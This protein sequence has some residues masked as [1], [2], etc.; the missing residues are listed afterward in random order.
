MPSIPTI[1]A[2]GNVLMSSSAS[3]NEWYLNGVVIFGANSQFYTAISNGF[4]VVMVANVSGCIAQS[5]A[6]NYST[7]GISEVSEQTEIIIYPNPFAYQAVLET[8]HPLK[9]ATI[10]IVNLLGQ[11]V[12]QKNNIDGQKIIIERNN[13]PAGVYFIGITENKK[14][15]VTKKIVV[16]D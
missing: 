8:N 1:T 6:Y 14:L 13:M 11:N 5:A 7:T 3:D 2:S 4:Y 16:A 9:D 10:N 12:L 15:I